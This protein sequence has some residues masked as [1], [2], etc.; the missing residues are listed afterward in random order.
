MAFRGSWQFPTVSWYKSQLIITLNGTTNVSVCCCVDFTWAIHFQKP[1][2]LLSEIP[3]NTLT[4]LCHWTWR[5]SENAKKTQHKGGKLCNAAVD[6]KL[7][8]LNRTLL[9]V[10]WLLK[11]RQRGCVLLIFAKKEAIGCEHQTSLRSLT[12]PMSKTTRESQCHS[13]SDELG[14]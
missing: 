13:S 12:R 2:N 7:L 14:V 6:H 11:L 5:E 9:P 8:K 10:L 1:S 4:N 3:M